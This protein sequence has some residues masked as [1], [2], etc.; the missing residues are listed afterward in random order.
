MFW[1]RNKIFFSVTSYV[2]AWRE[3]VKKNLYRT[4]QLKI[5][6]MGSER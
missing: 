4:T 6:F 3:A 2:G 1:L 5:S